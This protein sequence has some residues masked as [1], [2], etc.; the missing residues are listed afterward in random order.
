[1]QTSFQKCEPR[2]LFKPK[3]LVQVK[4]YYKFRTKLLQKMEEIK[5]MGVKYENGFFFII[6][7]LNLL[8]FK[9]NI[10]DLQ[11]MGL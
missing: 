8:K 9:I 3:P 11:I 1:M 5:W 2:G 10:A 4:I 6:S 7:L